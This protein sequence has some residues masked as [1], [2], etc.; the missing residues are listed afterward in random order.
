MLGAAIS[1]LFESLSSIPSAPVQQ[2]I[3]QEALPTLSNLMLEVRTDP[4]SSR[5]AAAVDL[6]DNIFDGW[7]V[8]LAPGV[9]HGVAPAIFEV[10]ATTEDRDLVQSG[11]HVL[12]TVVRKDVAQLLT[13]SVGIC[14]P[15]EQPRLMPSSE[16]EFERRAIGSRPRSR[17]SRPFTRSRRL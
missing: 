1:E 2:V 15:C 16:Q 3:L 13:W 9:F 6:V 12:T 11:L 5:A 10:L 14:S 4:F 8:P 17:S 7:S